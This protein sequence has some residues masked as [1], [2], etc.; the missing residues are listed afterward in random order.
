[1]LFLAAYSSLLMF[2]LWE[3]WL[4]FPADGKQ[5][6][7][8]DLCCRISLL[9]WLLFINAL[10]L[11]EIRQSIY[12][13]KDQTRLPPLYQGKSFT[14]RTMYIRPLIW[15]L[16][17]SIIT[18]L[19][20]QKIDDTPHIKLWWDWIRNVDVFGVKAANVPLSFK[21]NSNFGFFLSL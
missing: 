20:F 12:Y 15:C 11:C 7:S 1:M 18:N 16:I 17:S 10:T 19:N 8:F 21:I 6:K 14:P 13:C 3:G 2:V 9:K 5:G 4:Q